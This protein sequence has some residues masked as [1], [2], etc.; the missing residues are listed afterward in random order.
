MTHDS[1]A[2]ILRPKIWPAVGLLFGSMVF[3][4]IGIWMVQAGESFG[5]LCAGFF[6]PGIPL[7]IAKMLPG[8]TCLRISAKEIAVVN[9]F[10]V[11][12]I[13]WVDIDRFFVGELKHKGR[14]IRKM[15]VFNYVPSYDRAHLARRVSQIIANCD[16]GLPDTYGQEAEALADT[17]NACLNEFAP[18][19]RD[20]FPGETP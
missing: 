4:A 20:A 12:T 3:V 10:R 19:D 9:L 2:V 1:D 17:L 15:V 5:Y 8:S 6:A 11:T 14:T 13:D 7:A 16:G 18:K